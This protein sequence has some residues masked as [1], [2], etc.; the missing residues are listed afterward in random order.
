MRPLNPKRKIFLQAMYSTLK[1]PSNFS[2]RATVYSHGW[3]MLDPFSVTGE[4]FT[5][6]YAAV[7]DSV[8]VGLD[9][10]EKTNGELAVRIHPANPE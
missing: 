5:L 9:I 7:I 2:F 3:C 10:S 4:P 8:P 6:S 1:T